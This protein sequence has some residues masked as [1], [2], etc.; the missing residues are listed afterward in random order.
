MEKR[1]MAVREEQWIQT[2]AAAKQSGQ[3][4]QAQ[5]Q[6]QHK[7]ARQSPDRHPDDLNPGGVLQLDGAAGVGVA[8]QF[9]QIAPG[10]K[11]RKFLGLRGGF[12]AADQLPLVGVKGQP[13]P[14]FP[15]GG[16][17]LPGLLGAG[18]PDA[19]RHFQL[20]IPGRDAVPADQLPE[21]RGGAGPSGSCGS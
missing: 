5:S 15:Q 1:A 10:G 18:N 7:P 20:Q 11:A 13:E 8:V 17:G 21:I 3:P 4:G 2:I 19:F 16:P 6:R 14:R 9:Q 12:P